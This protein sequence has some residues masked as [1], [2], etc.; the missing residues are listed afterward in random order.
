MKAVDHIHY[1]PGLAQVYDRAEKKYFDPYDIGLKL[2]FWISLLAF[3]VDRGIDWIY[4][5]LAVQTA[6]LFSAALRF[7]HNGNFANYLVW[8]LVGAALVVVIIW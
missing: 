2:V 1:A 5:T 3:W 8:S 6:A 7:V 4:N